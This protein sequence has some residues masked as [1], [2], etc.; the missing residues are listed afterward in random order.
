MG[1]ET[2][3]ALCAGTGAGPFGAA[4]VGGTA[5]GASVGD[6]AGARTAVLLGSALIFGVALD[7]ASL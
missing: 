3:A 7:L 6:A 2:G 4:L 5:D 1:V